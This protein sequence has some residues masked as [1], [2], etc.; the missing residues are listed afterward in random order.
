M[1]EQE[2]NDLVAGIIP[3]AFVCFRRHAPDLFRQMETD[4]I[5][6]EL[7]QFFLDRFHKYDPDRGKP[8]TWAFQYVRQFI[9]NQRQWR[10]RKMRSGV[11]FGVDCDYLRQF[12]C[13]EQSVPDF[14]AEELDQ[15]QKAMSTLAPRDRDVLTLSLS[16]Q[17]MRVI[18]EKYGLTKGR[19]GQIR[20]RAIVMVGEKLGVEVDFR[21]GS[22]HA[23]ANG[24]QRRLL[25]K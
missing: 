6:Q 24:R 4:E 10:K 9:S 22:P 25:L 7:W 5:K 1:T 3:W 17:P 14:D 20:D 13:R 15:L 19:I 21:R 18:A 12:P 11:T 2:R 16:G 23:E 8:T